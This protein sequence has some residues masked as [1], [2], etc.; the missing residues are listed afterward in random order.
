MRYHHSKIGINN[1]DP[2]NR[3]YYPIKG[4]ILLRSRYAIALNIKYMQRLIYNATGG[5]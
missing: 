4:A 3:W 5:C 2:S 1:V